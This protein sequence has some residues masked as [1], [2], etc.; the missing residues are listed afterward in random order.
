MLP[1]APRLYTTLSQR[2]E[3]D[4]AM[5][6]LGA[7]PGYITPFSAVCYRMTSSCTHEQEIVLL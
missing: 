7:G 2:C 6:F 1:P 4:W 3:Q 5:G